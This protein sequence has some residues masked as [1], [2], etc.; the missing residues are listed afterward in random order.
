VWHSLLMAAGYWAALTDVLHRVL[1]VDRVVRGDAHELALAAAGFWVV[2]IA[3]AAVSGLSERELRR[4][5]AELAALAAMGARFDQEAT[6]LEV[7]A[8]LLTQ[9]L[10]VFGFPRAAVATVEAQGGWALRASR[11]G[12]RRRG[13]G[14]VT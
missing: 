10:D 7:A 14:A 6:P 13:D 12:A 11:A 9:V 8:V 5:K 1:G 2:A 4:G 3:T